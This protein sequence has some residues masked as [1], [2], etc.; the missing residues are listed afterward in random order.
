MKQ[1][2]TFL[3]LKKQIK[4][5]FVFSSLILG[6][7]ASAQ[8]THATFAS[9]LTGPS[10]MAKDSAG[11]IYIANYSATGTVVKLDTSGTVLNTFTGFAFPV[12]VA[13]DA[14]GSIYV[15]EKLSPNIVK[16]DASGSNRQNFN[17]S[18]LMSQP[19]GICVDG[20]GKLYVTSA[21]PTTIYGD[22]KILKMNVDGTG[23]QFIGPNT[24]GAV[25]SIAIGSAGNK[26]YIREGG[27]VRKLDLDGTNE[28]TLLASG[29]GVGLCLD[30]SDNVYISDNLNWVLKK[31]KNT[32]N[33]VSTIYNN[34]SFSYIIF[35]NAGNLYFN[36]SGGSDINKIVN[37]ALATQNVSNKTFSLS[38]NPAKDFVVVSG[39][40]KGT[41][42]SLF[43]VTGKLLFKSQAAGTSFTINTSSYQNGVYVVKVGDK[44]SKLIISK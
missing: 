8:I 31:I 39:V 20:N 30:A 21:V 26:L 27:R 44:T 17:I 32:D 3:N 29:D 22:Q 42:V 6:V 13:V 33:S 15:V 16:M 14:S 18:F 35:D 40:A 23:A 1:K 37:T 41:E 28:V 7:C 11:N 10:G 36:V 38:P 4:L 43:D 2:S 9:G 19:N 25:T 12:G 5:L 34:L 24:Y